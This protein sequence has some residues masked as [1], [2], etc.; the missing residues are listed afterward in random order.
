MGEEYHNCVLAFG[1]QV[2][3]RIV[4]CLHSL[5]GTSG[6]VGIVHP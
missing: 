3:Y 6:R 5:W 4:V 1:T 2:D